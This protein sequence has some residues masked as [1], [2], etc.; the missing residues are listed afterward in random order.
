MR[1]AA[2]PALQPSGFD[3]L[4]RR[5]S[6]DALRYA[7]VIVGPADA[8]DVCQEA[9]LRVWQFWSGSDSGRREAWAL[10]IV[11]NCALERRRWR[12]RRPVDAETVDGLDP[13]HPVVLEDLV[14]NRLEADD[15]LRRLAT[16][17]RRQRETLYLREVADLS[18]GEIANIQGIPA[19]TVMSRLHA[20]RRQMARFAPRKN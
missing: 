15:A 14:V 8:E 10:R 19:G 1:D 18:Y 5:R 6:G 11:R 9:W 16:L 2:Q 4:Y 12:Q 7:A 13:S 17:P 3:E 20:A